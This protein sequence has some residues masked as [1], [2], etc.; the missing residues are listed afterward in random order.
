MSA[1]VITIY[2]KLLLQKSPMKLYH[3]KEKLE[4]NFSNSSKAVLKSC[5]QINVTGTKLRSQFAIKEK[6]NT[7]I[8][9]CTMLNAMT[10]M[11]TTLK[12]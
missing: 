3:I 11:I 9:S 12:K 10:V 1:A 4:K 7:S 2:L 5:F 8:T 6:K